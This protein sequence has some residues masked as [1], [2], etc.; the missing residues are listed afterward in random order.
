MKMHNEAGRILKNPMRGGCRN[1]WIDF[2]KGLAIIAVVFY[3]LGIFEYG[4]LGV[5]MFLVINGYLI[6]NSICKQIRNNDFHWFRYLV[7]RIVRIWPLIVLSCLAALLVGYFT[8]LPDDLE[9]LSESVVASNFFANN[10]LSQITASDYW[11][12][13]Q[14]YKPLMHLWYIGIVVQFYIVYIAAVAIV[15]RFSDKRGRDTGRALRNFLIA[16]TALGFLLYLFCSNVSWR[17]YLLPFR[18]WEMTFG[19]LLTFFSAGIR[20]ETESGGHY[21]G[22]KTQFN[23]KAGAAL[24][25]AAAAL[26]FIS[27]EDLLPVTMLILTVLIS[28]AALSGAQT[29]ITFDRK[30]QFPLRIVAALG[31]C[32]YSI[33]IWHQV[34]LAFYRYVITSSMGFADHIIYFIIL[35]AVSALSYFVVEKGLKDLTVKKEIV[36]IAVSAVLC[37][38]T[39]GAGLFLYMNSGVVRDVPELDISTDNIYRGMHAAYND[40]VYDMDEEFADDGRIKVLVVGDSFGRDWVNILLE[41]DIADELDISY[42]YYEDLSEEYADRI[43]EADYIFTN[44]SS[45]IDGEAYDHYDDIISVY[46]SEDAIWY[47]IGTKRYGDSNG[48]VYSHRNEDDYYLQ[49][50]SYASVEE[51]YTMEK[52]V[53]GDCY[54]DFIAPVLQENG[55]VSAFTDDNKYISQDCRHLTQAG[56]RYYAKILDL[57]GIFGLE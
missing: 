56:A 2:L 33:F 52:Q 54:V 9:N 13:S 12:V 34:I 4:Y 8:M 28:G 32:S 22:A 23:T 57:E 20:P 18:F 21:A 19:G 31:V 1:N 29:G 48:N 16:V 43:K 47:G 15:K 26:V 27:S 24:L 5:D 55:E 37:I 36:V 3:H 25:A 7:R 38:V 17:F 41:S 44:A 30:W 14:E 46:A 40:R 53:W 11:D 6:T 51:A 49:T 10:I 50:V 35:A 45:R 39:S 42:V